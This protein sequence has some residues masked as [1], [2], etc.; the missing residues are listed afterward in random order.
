[1]KERTL[2]EIRQMFRE[3]RFATEGIGAV[4]TDAKPGSAKCEVA[5][6]AI[7]Q[8]ARG[9]VMGGVIFTLAD[10]AVAVAANAYKETPDTV[11]LHGGINFL[12]P[13]KGKRLLAEAICVKAGRTTSL[14][15]VMVTDELDTLVAQVTFNGFTVGR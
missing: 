12:T 6:N 5:L 13:A 1:M 14:Y 9:A 7:H 10:F 2:E 4:I 15:E 11:T 3:D 8:N